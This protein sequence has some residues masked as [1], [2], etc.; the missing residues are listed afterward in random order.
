MA[1]AMGGIVR[2]SSR[3]GALDQCQFLAGEIVHDTQNGDP[4]APAQRVRDEVQRSA[5]VRPLR[6]GQRLSRARRPLAAA[7]ATD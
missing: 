4:P 3:E 2:P 6:Q 5:L 1:N 7:S